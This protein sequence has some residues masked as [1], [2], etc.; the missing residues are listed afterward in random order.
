M[1]ERSHSLKASFLLG[2]PLVNFCYL[3]IWRASTSLI[4]SILRWGPD[5][6]SADGY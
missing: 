4:Y 5:D 3:L 1:I 6:A 2:V